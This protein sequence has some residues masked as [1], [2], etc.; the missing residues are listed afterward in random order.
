MITS[1]VPSHDKSFEENTLC[2]H[3]KIK[4]FMN[5]IMVGSD[6]RKGRDDSG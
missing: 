1:K 4:I 5:D 6:N 2:K 3:S